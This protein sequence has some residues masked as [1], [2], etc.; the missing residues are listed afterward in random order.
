MR[1][2]LFIF[3]C[4]A[5]SLSGV[6]ASCAEAKTQR[7]LFLGNSVFYSRGGLCPSFEGF[8]RE[9]GLDYE[10]VS[11]WH[12][13][14]E[15]KGA[16]HGIEFLGYGRI[17][18]NLPAV[19]ADQKI[20]ALIRDGDFDYVILEGRREG[21]LLPPEAGLAADRGESI[22]Y[23]QNIAALKSLHKTIV[24]SGAQT[25]LYMHPGGH[26][27]VIT[28]HVVGQIY[29][30]FHADLEAMKIND[31]RH[32]VLFVP[33]MNLWLDAMQRYGVERWFVDAHHGTAL[34]RYASACLLYTYITGR[35]PRAN[36]YKKLT[37]LTRD[38]RVI[39]EKVNLEAS[40]GDARW[41]KDQVW[42]YYSTRGR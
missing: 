1:K 14:T 3:L 40:D 42:L 12:G 39:P 26:A 2:P 25:V 17:P 11:Q 38:W 18:L 35:D 8:C 37:E 9:A 29:R 21:Y 16:A 41:I 22:P 15:G 6:V 30:R 10:A 20:H 7:V 27:D 13:P 32:D 34:A 19:A 23:A 33:A 5:I 36:A 28:K 24:E 4:G 31:K